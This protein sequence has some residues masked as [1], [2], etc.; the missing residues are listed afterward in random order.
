[1]TIDD[2]DLFHF[3]VVRTVIGFILAV[4][5]EYF[6]VDSV[7]VAV[8]VFSVTCCL[9]IKTPQTAVE[10]QLRPHSIWMNFDQ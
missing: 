1:M 2:D 9:L 8:G 4:Q 7:F 10:C 5:K 3:S 6:N